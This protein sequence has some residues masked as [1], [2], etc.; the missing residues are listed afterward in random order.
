MEPSKEQ[1]CHWLLKLQQHILGRQ[2]LEAPTKV[3]SAFSAGDQTQ[4]LVLFAYS[5][6][7][8]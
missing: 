2:D 7:T 8:G 6:I 4:S 5:T 1:G 3:I